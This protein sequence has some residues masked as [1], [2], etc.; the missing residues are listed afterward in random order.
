MQSSVIVERLCYFTVIFK[1]L[2]FSTVK[3]KTSRLANLFT[4]QL[5]SW[6]NELKSM[7]ST[8][9]AI[10][11]K[12]PRLIELLI[13]EGFLP[14]TFREQVISELAL[15]FMKDCAGKMVVID[16]S[17]S[18]GTTFNKIYAFSTEASEKWSNFDKIVGLPF[19]VGEKVKNECLD[20]IDKYF[21]PLKQNEITSFVNSE[22]I[23]FQL[24]GKPFDLE[25]PIL[26]VLGDFDNENEIESVLGKVA[27]KLEGEVIPLNM[28]VSTADETISSKSWTL[29]FNRESDTTQSIAKPE[30]KKIRVYLN[31]TKN[32]LNI[33]A[34]QPV[35]LSKNSFAEL[36]KAFP[37]AL[38]DLWLMV[39][40]TVYETFPEHQLSELFN[41]ASRRSLCMW[42]NF[43]NSMLLLTT[44]KKEFFEAMANIGK[45]DFDWNG[46]NEYDLQLLIGRELAV[47]S[48]KILSGILQEG[49]TIEVQKNIFLETLREKFSE[50]D[51]ERIPK[52]Y[53]NQYES[54]L[55]EL[56]SAIEDI[57]VDDTL[58]AIFHAQHHIEVL[59]RENSDSKRLDF[60]LTYRRLI[61]VIRE[62]VP[63][64][65]EDVINFCFDRLIDEGCIVPR[66]I[67]MSDA[68]DPIDFWVRAFRVGEATVPKPGLVNKFLFDSL[69]RAYKNDGLIPEFLMEKFCVLVLL[70]YQKCNN[71]ANLLN[72]AE[73]DK[74]YDIKGARCVINP[75]GTKREFLLEWAVRNNI[76]VKEGL[77]YGLDPKIDYRIESDDTPIDDDTQDAVED[78]ARFVSLI[79]RNEELRTKA[80]TL[81][82]SVASRQE[83]QKAVREEL[84]LWIY[85]NSSI[86]S[87]KSCIQ[88][89][90]I[91]VNSE[92]NQSFAEDAR[93]KVD[94]LLSV[95]K[96]VDSKREINQSRN[97][98]FSLIDEEL[99]K[100]ENKESISLTRL[101]RN[102]KKDCDS[103]TGSDKKFPENPR[104]TCIKELADL[105]NNI[106][107]QFLLSLGA[108]FND[109]KNGE[110]SQSM[111]LLKDFILRESDPV[112]FDKSFGNSVNYCTFISD[113]INVI[114]ELEVR[115]PQ[116][117]FLHLEP[118]LNKISELCETVWK[119]FSDVGEFTT[120][121]INRYGYVLTWDKIESTNVMN[122]MELQQ[123][124]ES[125]NKQIASLGSQIKYFNTSLNDGNRLICK[126]FRTVLAVFGIIVDGFRNV[127]PSGHRFGCHYSEVTPSNPRQEFEYSGRIMDFFK[128]IEK[129]NIWGGDEK[130]KP[131][132]PESSYLIISEAAKRRAEKTNTWRIDRYTVNSP[133]GI[134]E[135]SLKKGEVPDFPV[136]IITMTI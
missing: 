6:A 43:L 72:G 41:G 120:A 115:S 57:N 15:P 97:E 51:G 92:Y 123:C 78:M 29:T 8:V 106:V 16:D 68:R 32:K 66:Y 130:S 109:N 101:W 126:N 11:R 18:N 117:V 136:F 54:K 28:Q 98:I 107:D 46:P 86:Q 23:A 90:S 44:F 100:L 2:M 64:A 19:G 50:E 5:E 3:H 76:F 131:K 77:C 40:E 42:A 49:F 56:T 112:V 38:K 60:G 113:K 125:T 45:N 59:S 31:Q 124:I 14:N 24:L 135:I 58:R 33:T 30:F 10:S 55:K 88:S 47:K 111:A 52:E 79:Y 21:L 61:A 17:V 133:P 48:E 69:N 70:K 53:K 75:C 122:S 22:V 105:T 37:A 83:L 132:E 62:Y 94:N 80:L 63:D 89:I 74:D 36:E 34:M 13:Y 12:G 85:G 27:L 39:Y 127:V 25:Y 67:N 81:L 95:M 71:I 26:S 20:N 1:D 129:P 118:A 121:D 35:I 84:R 119:D 102:L 114:S 99:N 65:K 87:L 9:L 82:T 116:E 7:D 93:S 73:L 96:E 103:L 91:L 128:E 110:F 104:I 134:Y 4:F 108:D